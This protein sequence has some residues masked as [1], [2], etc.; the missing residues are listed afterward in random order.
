MNPENTYHRGKCH[1][2][3]DLLFDW[4]GFDQTSKADANSTSVKQLNQNKTSRR[5]AV[6]SYS[7]D[8]PILHLTRIYFL[9]PLP[10]VASTGSPMLVDPHL[11]QQHAGLQSCSLSTT[12][13]CNQTYGKVLNIIYL[14]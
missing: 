7:P 14:V 4:F 8:E 1:C 3:T 6:Q 11:S 2:T 12:T 10:P 13:G 9:T 5:S